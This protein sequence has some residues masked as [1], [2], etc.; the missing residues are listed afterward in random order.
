MVVVCSFLDCLSSMFGLVVRVEVDC[1]TFGGF[2]TL[3]VIVLLCFCCCPC[4]KNKLKHDLIC[5]V[6]TE[7]YGRHYTKV[8]LI[9][10][11]YY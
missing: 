10:A 1:M 11:L 9:L 4:W 5:T 2:F 7:I 8:V 3:P 6:S